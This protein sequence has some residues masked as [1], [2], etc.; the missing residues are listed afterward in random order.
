MNEFIQ[1]LDFF[2]EF[3]SNPKLLLTKIGIFVPVSIFLSI[4][5][6]KKGILPDYLTFSLSWTLLM[7][8]LLFLNFEGLYFF[9]SAFVWF[10]ILCGIRALTSRGIGLG[11][12]KY[13]ISISLV[14]G[15]VGTAISLV[16]AS[17]LALIPYFYQKILKKRKTHSDRQ[18][19]FGPFLFFGTLACQVFLLLLI[20]I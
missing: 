9:L 1:G 18:I 20:R 11:D 19:R 16:F 12:L 10:M 8:N 15:L 4:I 3:Q 14:T 5:D 6:Q 2:Q 13:I 17:L 7:V